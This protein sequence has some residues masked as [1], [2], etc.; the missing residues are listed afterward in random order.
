MI[1]IVLSIVAAALIWRG[2]AARYPP[3]N[4]FP[5]TLDD[6][7]FVNRPGRNYR[8]APSSLYKGMATDGTDP[9]ADIDALGAAQR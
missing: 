5:A 8:L 2:K 3:D 7:G 6:V 4:F 1:R 9:G